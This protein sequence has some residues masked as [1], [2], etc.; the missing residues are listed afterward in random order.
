MMQTK[1]GQLDI[2]SDG[3]SNL[4]YDVVVCFSSV[5]SLAIMSPFVWPRNA[6]RHAPA[7]SLSAR[8]RAAEVCLDAD[9]TRRVNPNP[10]P[11]V[12]LPTP[13]APVD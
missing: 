12:F 5:R 13:A 11:P 3:L 2:R 10:T 1:N 9:A 6:E 4:K 7:P 8:H